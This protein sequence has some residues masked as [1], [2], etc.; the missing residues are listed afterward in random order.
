[1]IDQH[2]N[3]RERPEIEPWAES[4]LEGL[5]AERPDLVPTGLRPDTRT[6]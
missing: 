5:L 4:H 2:N 1:V 6:L 3:D